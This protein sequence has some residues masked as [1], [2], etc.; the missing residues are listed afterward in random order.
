VVSSGDGRRLQ[1]LVSKLWRWREAL[2]A[3]ESSGRGRLVGRRLRGRQLALKAGASSERRSVKS[4]G[5]KKEGLEAAAH[6]G[7]GERWWWRC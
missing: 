2:E 6:G 7:E 1:M 4:S 3:A 5:G